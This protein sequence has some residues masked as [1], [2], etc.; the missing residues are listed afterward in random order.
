MLGQDPAFRSKRSWYIVARVKRT[1]YQLL[2][3]VPAYAL[4]TMELLKMAIRKRIIISV[5]G[6]ILGMGVGFATL[7]II[8]GGSAAEGEK[9]AEPFGQVVGLIFVLGLAALWLPLAIRIGQK[10]R[11]EIERQNKKKRKR[12]Q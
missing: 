2:E 8:S 4:F 7:Y 5:V 11:A 10:R 6:L 12:R 3:R 1:Q 9:L